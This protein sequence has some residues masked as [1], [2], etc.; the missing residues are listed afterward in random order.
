VREDSAIALG[1]V[2]RAYGGEALARVM[3]QLTAM[4]VMAKDQPS[5]SAL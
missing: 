3:P 4:L 5:E 2:M 1:D